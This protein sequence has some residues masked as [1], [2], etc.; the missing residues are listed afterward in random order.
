MK[1]AV[2][3]RFLGS[4]GSHN[5]VLLGKQSNALQQSGKSGPHSKKYRVSRFRINFLILLIC[6]PS[7]FN[8]KQAYEIASL[9]IKL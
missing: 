1:D 6:I 8:I 2:Q 5:E 3:R 4:A 9:F 7:T